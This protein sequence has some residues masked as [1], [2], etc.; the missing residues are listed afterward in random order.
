MRKFMKQQA[1]Q[2]C[3]LQQEL[4]NLKTQIQQ[5]KQCSLQDQAAPSAI[6]VVDDKSKPDSN[7]SLPLPPPASQ[8]QVQAVQAVQAQAPSASQSLQVPVAP[9]APTEIVSTL[10]PSEVSQITPGI[11][12]LLK[13]RE[14]FQCQPSNSKDMGNTLQLLSPKMNPFFNPNRNLYLKG[15]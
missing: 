1:Q 11:Q 6:V 12:A 8:A 2:I 14:R 5:C 3:L 7:T 15:Y 9:T 10:T 4:K 13:E